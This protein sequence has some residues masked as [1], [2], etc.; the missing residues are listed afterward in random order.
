MNEDTPM[1]ARNIKPSLFTNEH[2]AAADP[3]YTVI[4]IGLWCIADREGRLPY[5]PIKIHYAINPGRCIEGTESA[6]R[7]LEEHGFIASYE[8]GGGRYI[9]IINF[10]RHQN[11][12]PRE[13]QSE[14]PPRDNLGCA[15][16]QPRQV[17]AGLIPDS[18]FPL[19]DSGSPITQGK[20]ARPDPHD[21]QFEQ[22]RAAYPKR[23]GGERLRDARRAYEARLREGAT[24]DMILDGVRRYAAFC[25]ADGKIGTPY[26]QQLAT[27]L[28]TNRGYLM[29]WNPP[30]KLE[31]AGERKAREAREALKQWAQGGSDASQ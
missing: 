26:V 24:F 11:P 19:I 12:H 30:P 18:G 2:L 7:W 21:E 29:P 23:S 31:T 14:I 9:D 10:K 22:I 15:M 28:G 1:R 20:P 27:F 4:F 6:L 5:R 13:S 25:E 3:L 16:A 17:P 8:V